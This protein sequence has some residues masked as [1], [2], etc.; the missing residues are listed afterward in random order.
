[1]LLEV[2]RSW[3][4]AC[5]VPLTTFVLG[6]SGLGLGMALSDFVTDV[7]KNPM[8]PLTKL[9]HTRAKDDRRRRI[10]GYGWLLA[11]VLVWGALGLYWLNESVTCAASS[12]G[13]FRLSL[14]LS[15]VYLLV[16]LVLVLV[17]L[18]LAIDFCL[19][20]KLRMVVIFEQ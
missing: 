2:V 16:V 5:D 9:E 10:V 15:G 20:G 4:L 12:P 1:M 3:Q 8:P 13:I 7:F 18:A 6:A 14:L 19:S 17:L 11:L